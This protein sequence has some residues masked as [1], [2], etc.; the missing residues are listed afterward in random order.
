[1]LHF[2]RM[3][4]EALAGCLPE[5]ARLRLAVFREW[6]YLY[7]G[8]SAYEERYLRTYV[9]APDSVVVLARDG[10]A[11]V[12][13]STAIPLA[14]ETTEVQAPFLAAGYAVGEIFY[15]GESVLL[16]AY[17]GQGAGVAFF[18]HREA[19]ARSRGDCRHSC[20]CA[21]ERPPDH[22][23]R[24][25]DYVPLDPFWQRRG[26]RIQPRLRTHFRWREIGE[27]SESP[28]PMTCW[29]KTLR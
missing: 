16:P 19:H 28:K 1:M 18:E 26:Y 24:P 23:A 6:P 8:D 2:E 4:G 20:F 21:V 22:P 29:M 10:R 3:S 11:I 15:F 27:T 7:D 13:A 5:L 17:R 25:E 9:S 12:G 14:D